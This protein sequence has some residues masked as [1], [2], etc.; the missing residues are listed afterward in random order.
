MRSIRTLGQSLNVLF[1]LAAGGSSV[2]A[3]SLPEIPIPAGNINLK[4]IDLLFPQRPAAGSQRESVAVQWRGELVNQEGPL[5]T[6]VNGLLEVEGTGGN[7]VVLRAESIS[8]NHLDQSIKASGNVVLEHPHYKM[9]CQQLEL[10]L[11]VSGENAIRTGE[12][13]GAIFELPPSWVLAAKRVRFEDYPG[14]TLGILGKLLGGGKADRTTEF[15]FEDASVSPCPDERPNWVANA[16]RIHLKTGSYGNSSG[17]GYATLNNIVLRIG[18]APIMWMPWALFPARV[19]RAPGL[20]PPEFGYSSQLGAIVGMSYFQPLGDAADA[21]ISPT[22]HSK[23]GTM[24]ALESRWEPG[25]THKGNFSARYI[26]PKDTGEA[27]YR[28]GLQEICDLENGWFVR[29]DINS[30]SDQLMDTEFGKSAPVPIGAPAYDSTLFVG[31]N[32]KWAALSLFASDNRSFFQPDDP[33]YNY[34][35]PASLQKI[36][37]P[38]GQLRF[39]PVPI[40]NFYLDGSLRIGQ[41]GYYLDL[42]EDSPISKYTWERSDHQIRLQGHLGRWGPLRADLQ[43]GARFT[44]YSA[45]ISDPLLDAEE[46]LGEEMASANPID[47]PAFDPFR[48]EGPSAQRWV[49]SSRLLFSAPQIGR[50]F[51]NLNF[52]GYNGDI[53][54]ILEPS[55][56]F[57]FNSRSSL[58]GVFPKFD[59]ADTRPGVEN[60]VVGERSIE[61]GLKQHLFGRPDSSQSYADLLRARITVKY[62]VDPIIYYDGREKQGWASLNTYVDV[63]P[64][65]AIKLSF[66]RA[67]EVSN[68]ESD[69][70][71]SA[72]VAVSKTTK[73]SL[74]AFSSGK[75][76]L[77]IRQR[78][79]RAGGTQ[80]IWGDKLGLQFEANY[81]F[82]RK[83]FTQSQVA[84]IFGSPCVAFSL[85][86]YHIYLPETSRYRKEDKIS[87]SLNLKNLG[88][89]FSVDFGNLF[90]SN[91]NSNS[92]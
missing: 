56:A 63:E 41:F 73:F 68:G 42:G 6:L 13:L 52:A 65:R 5:L 44:H 57:S 78:G 90:R 48:V 88:E 46:D 87:F 81:D 47:D 12:A 7:T 4:D 43:L 22:W 76:Q 64:T 62:Y 74:A 67:T 51:L 53:K 91:S 31:K 37:M 1:A 92:K 89:L 38:E 17:Q 27:R 50:S 18:P 80:N 82:V 11:T 10:R 16:S 24:W 33:F 3:Q 26:R 45:V 2:V 71:L 59:E 86:Y 8:F 66:K 40:G 14:D 19:D 83:T 84:L 75:N 21:T 55:I 9:S 32:F 85:S 35:F 72:D 77:R 58:A 23:V 30:A 15:R 79:I 49:G 34:N 28:F 25:I 36:K 60:T 39:F 54:H 29:A 69:S 61:F 20:L 70:S